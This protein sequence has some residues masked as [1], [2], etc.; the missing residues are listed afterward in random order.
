LFSGIFTITA[1]AKILV[2]VFRSSPTLS[3]GA[4]AHIGI[5]MMLVGMMFSSGYSKV[6][7]LNNTGMMISRELSDEF[8]RENLLLFVNE[9]RTMSDYRIE[10]KGERLEP[11]NKNGF[12][13]HNDID[14]TDDPYRV[15]AKNDILFDG[16]LLYKAKDTF[17]ILPENTYYEIELVNARGKSH[18]LFPRIQDNPTMG[19]AASPDIKR[20][21]SKDL[22]AHVVTKTNRED[23]EWSETE[24]IKV[25][26]NQEFY[27]NDYVSILESV[28]R[29]FAIGSTKLDSTDV[30]VKATI[31]VKGE[32]QEFI[33]DPIFI[34]RNRMAGRIPHEI[35]DLG[36]RLTLM[37][38]H[39]ETNQF[40]IGINTRQK[41]FIVLK[42]LEKP[43][44]NVLWIGTLVLMGGFTVAIIR[45]YREF[46]KMKEKGVEV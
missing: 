2:S 25:A 16:D 18:T 6:V 8:N 26:A 45:R 30:A 4:I 14:P 13:N 3:G 20:D 41:D 7:S 35:K 28:E 32:H 9:P 42:A 17:D 12:V 5:G 34:I 27:A 22:Y 15:V 10:Y 37:N 11:R 23:I 21:A 29:I 19:R 38:I 36:I 40:T 44:I 39:P 46:K 24:E 33:A 43:M 1:N 31:R